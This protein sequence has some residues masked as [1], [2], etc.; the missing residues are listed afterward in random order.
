[1]GTQ[2]KLLRFLEEKTFRRVGGTADIHIDVRVIAATNC[3]LEEAVRKH[4]FR[5]D[6]YYRLR[7]MPVT[8]PPLRDRPADVPLLVKSMIDHFNPEFGRHIEGAS[9][10]AL[11]MLQAHHW[12]GNVR[13]LRNAV[14]GAML[15]CARETLEETDFQ[16]FMKSELQEEIIL[17]PGG[18][19][20]EDLE[21]DLVRQA[22][23]RSG[24]NHARAG[25][26][27]GMNR[28]QIRYRIAKF[29]LADSQ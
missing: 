2:A 15:L 23:E 11:A 6:L 9:P 16:A 21:R 19:I 29:H 28:D 3:R 25:T 20:F 7:V 26:L 24:G 13:E 14:E 18:I 8:M 17:P 5:E 10:A 1:L 4:T 27:L 22:L 12:P